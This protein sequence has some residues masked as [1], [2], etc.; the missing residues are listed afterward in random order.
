M[1]QEPLKTDL[2]QIRQVSAPNAILEGLPLTRQHCRRKGSERHGF[3]KELP[4]TIFT[5]PHQRQ[6]DNT[7]KWNPTSGR[8]M[9]R[10]RNLPRS[11]GALLKG[12]ELL[13][14]YRFRYDFIKSRHVPQNLKSL[15]PVLNIMYL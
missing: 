4:R 9:G 2:P 7:P 11:M 14:C 15:Q 6:R 12:T 5:N 8:P 13:I 1:R 10:E 3:T